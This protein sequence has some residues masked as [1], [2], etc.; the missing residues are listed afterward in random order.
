MLTDQKYFNVNEFNGNSNAN[1]VEVHSSDESSSILSNI[2][3]YNATAATTN[4]HLNN[5]KSPSVRLLTFN[6]W[7]LK[8]ISKHREERIKAFAD[9]IYNN[10]KD[11][12]DIIA[13]QEIWV[14]NDWKYIKYK[15]ETIFP[16][17]RFFYS[18]IVSGP[19]LAIL[20]RIPIDSTFLYRFPIN[21]RPSAFFR[22]DWYVGKSISITL[23]KSHSQNSYPI[24]ILNSH[25]HAPYSLTGDAA[26]DCHRACQ[27][28]DFSKFARSLSKIGYAVIVVGDLNSRPGSLPHK[29]L[30]E[31]GKLQD[32]WEI[33][34]MKKKNLP[35][36]LEEIKNLS[37]NLQITVGGTTCD[38]VLNTY[39]SYL[40]PDRACRLD[41]ALVNNRIEPINAEVQFT[42]EIPNIGSYSDHFA[43]YVE[44]NVKNVANN[45]NNNNNFQ[46]ENSN[47]SQISISKEKNNVYDRVQNYKEF[48]L[49]IKDYQEK[50]NKTKQFYWRICHVIASSIAI[51]FFHFIIPAASEMSSFLSF[52]ILFVSTGLT[53]SIMANAMILFFF[54][55]SE[56]RALEEVKQEVIDQ[57]RSLSEHIKE[58]LT[59]DYH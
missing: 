55:P 9:R 18:G 50:T 24:A 39:R 15:L 27:A 33:L 13:L 54:L 40:P 57:E 8:Y 49:L 21:G 7:G 23:L 46:F 6:L 2:Y 43:Y 20:S 5:K 25:M 14:E 51:I 48:K 47:E 42:E 10:D 32:S 58:L 30:T 44:F 45:N 37:P 29:F 56:Y 53:V 3:T 36:S 35:I 11:K 59:T 41:Y 52:L 12:Y 22:G 31:E 38:S 19:G 26:Y 4:N 17:S 34:N 1:D 16:Y 28:W